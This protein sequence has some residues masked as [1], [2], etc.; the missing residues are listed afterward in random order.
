MT[1]PLDTP[2]IYNLF[3]RLA[4]PMDRWAGHARRAAG[5]GF[6][7]LYVNSLHYPGFSGS[8]YAVKEYYRINPLFLPHAVADNGLST[9]EATLAELRALGLRPVMDLVI[10]HTS[11]D[12]P[13]VREHPEWYVRDTAGGVVSPSAMDPADSRRRTVWGDL[14]EMDNHGSA[15]RQGL[16]E[17]WGELVRRFLTLGFE[18]FRCDAAYKVP[19]ELWRYLIEVGRATKPEVRFFAETLGASL[20]EVH[21]LADAGL[22]F[23]F[24]SSKWWAFDQ[25]WCLEQHAQFNALAPSISFPESHDTPRLAQETGGNQAVQ[26]G[27]YAFAAAFSA[28]LM[29]TMGYEYGLR[30]PLNVVA[31]TPDDWDDTAMDLT[32]FVERVNRLKLGCPLLQGEG[33]LEAVSPLDASTLVLRR[34]SAKAAGDQGWILINKSWSE[35]GQVDLSGVAGVK[36]S[37][38]LVAPCRDTA[39]ASV[40]PAA[41]RVELG[42]AE[43]MLLLPR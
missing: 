28:G 8:L 16:W 6:N 19:A 10:N 32:R 7:W 43:V 35:P 3:P 41:G 23:F 4:G 27:R 1:S 2:L 26:R 34:A 24:N 30:K 29:M 18:G 12:C 36:P 37:H 22:D 20:D 11:K 42:P 31:T 14:A 5:M 9:L 15:D 13:L 39:K 38:Q 40:K 33:E 25:P 17:F 21:R